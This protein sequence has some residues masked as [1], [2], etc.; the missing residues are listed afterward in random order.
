M[1]HYLH[2]WSN[3]AKLNEIILCVQRNNYFDS[4]NYLY[5][6]RNDYLYIQR[7]IYIFNGIIIFIQPNNDSIYG[8][9]NINL[10][11]KIW[12][13][14]CMDLKKNKWKALY[15]PSHN[16]YGHQTWQNSDL[17]WGEPTFK[18]MLAFDYVVLWQIEKTYICSSAIPMV[19]KLVKVVTCVG[20]PQ[21]QS[22][23]SFWLRGHVTNSNNLHLHF[24]NTYGH[25]TWQSGNLPSKNPT[26]IVRWPFEQ[27]VTW[28][29]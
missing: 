5:I 22:H 19:N 1:L 21:L 6:Q 17:H 10:G 11:I 13:L 27:V 3:V 29:L 25:Q 15:L 16:T 14:F 23:V 18:A 9:R 8:Q 28:H 2:G 20:V 4:T 24:C 26:Y 12:S 7:I